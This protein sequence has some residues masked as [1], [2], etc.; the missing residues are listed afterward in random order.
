[1]KRQNKS[2]IVWFILCVI[3]MILL[4]IRVATNW[5]LKGALLVFFILGVVIEIIWVVK[6]AIKLFQVY[7]HKQNKKTK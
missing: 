4:T 6:N 5:E 3:A 7:K 1:M 2:S